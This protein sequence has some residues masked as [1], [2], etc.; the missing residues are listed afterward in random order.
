MFEKGLYEKIGYEKYKNYPDYRSKYLVL[1]SVSQISFLMGFISDF[2]FKNNEPIKNVLEIGI[3]NGVTSLYML[4]EGKI[5]DYKHIGIDIET[6]SKFFGEAVDREASLDEKKKYF[7]Y[8][9]QTALDIEEILKKEQIEKLDL[10][11]IDAGHSHPFPLIDLICVLPFIHDETIVVLHD[12]VD[13]MRPNAWG[14]SFIF[15]AWE[16]GKYRNVNIE[17]LQQPTKDGKVVPNERNSSSKKSEKFKEETMG[18]ISIPNNKEELYRTLLKIAK[19]PFRA[20]PWKFDE[21]YLGIDENLI[22]RLENFLYRHYDKN[23]A[24]EFICCFTKNLASYKEEYILRIH[25]TRF[26]N[27]I[28]E[29][30]LKNQQEIRDLESKYERLKKRSLFYI[31]KNIKDKMLFKLKS[32]KK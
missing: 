3:F 14:E 11:F 30:L 23:F 10:V 31:L 12:V 24:D 13:Y 1:T 20:T 21:I 5:N 15:E 28:Y 9:G 8:L 6:D 7:K 17:D 2:K 25:E 32:F 27:W 19:Q 18:I 16:Y 26:Y 4:K 22:K 29:T